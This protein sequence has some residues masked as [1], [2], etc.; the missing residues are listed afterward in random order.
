MLK[1]KNI[2]K[3]F[4]AN[5]VNEKHMFSHF[6][7]SVFRGEFVT[8][9]GSNGAGKS[10]L[11]NI[12]AGVLAPDGG[13]I[14]LNGRDVTGLSEHRRACFMGRVFQDPLLGT[15][16]NMTIE[17]NLSLAFNRAH[18]TSLGWGLNP[19]L[20]EHF[21]GAL[22]ALQLGLEGRLNTKVKYLSGG[23]RQAL[24]LLMATLTK[25]QLLLLDEHSAALDPNTAV[26]INDLTERIIA[27]NGITTLMV[28][29]NMEN[30]IKMGNRLIMLQEGKVILDIRGLQ[31]SRLSVSKLLEMFRE[32]Q[33]SDFSYD[34]ALLAH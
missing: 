12:I 4:N 27:D 34:E 16:P 19:R 7:L 28:T 5:T 14:I 18:N 9:I 32:A 31:K 1:L 8:I 20:R 13:R 21:R 22:A 24:T 3:V 15:S 29:H 17:E 11:L 2:C 23:Q 30:A 26:Q 10:T 6:N 33:G 25:P